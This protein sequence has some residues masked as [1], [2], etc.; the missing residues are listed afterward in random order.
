LACPERK[1]RWRRWPGAAGIAAAPGQAEQR[2]GRRKEGG[3]GEADRWGPIISV[4]GKKKKK[5]RETGRCGSELMGR[6]AAG[7]ERRG[8]FLCF[9]FSFSNSFQ[10]KLFLSNSNQNSSNLF[11]KFYKLFRSHTSNQ[12]P[13]KSK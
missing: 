5:K 1:G 7:P 9:F 6:W 10:I 4:R 12:K 11:T 8:G 2:G 3:R 13:C